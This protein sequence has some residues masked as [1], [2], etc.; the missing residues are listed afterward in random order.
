MRSCLTSACLAAAFV[1][2]P[3][4]A[5]HAAAP[6]KSPFTVTNDPTQL[7]T[8][9]D[10]MLQR[11]CSGT[12]M[13]LWSWQGETWVVKGVWYRRPDRTAWV[14]LYYE[15]KGP[16]DLPVTELGVSA[17]WTTPPE[18]SIIFVRRTHYAV[19]PA[20]DNRLSGATIDPEG[21]IDMTCE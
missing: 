2:A 21:L 19:W 14:K 6:A 10:T 17:Q 18:G 3:A 1:L 9:I 15:G 13:P 8:V 7:P 11:S 20:G 16:A 12:V 4:F 5:G